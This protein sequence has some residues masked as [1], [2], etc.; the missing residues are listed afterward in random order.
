MALNKTVLISGQTA[1]L[2]QNIIR[3]TDFS[4][5]VKLGSDANNFYLFSGQT[6][7]SSNGCGIFAD[8][9]AV[10]GRIG[11]S[12]ILGLSHRFDE[13]FGGLIEPPLGFANSSGCAT[14]LQCQLIDFCIAIVGL[15][16]RQPSNSPFLP[17]LTDKTN[18]RFR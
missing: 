2:P 13:F 9:F 8:A 7:H 12:S 1:W 18:H 15:Q 6:H 3:D 11:I 4:D 17:Q 10:T 14:E 16:L 5:V